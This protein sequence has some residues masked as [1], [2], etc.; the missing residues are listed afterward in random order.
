MSF[1][2]DLQ[3]NLVNGVLRLR[4][5]HYSVNVGQSFANE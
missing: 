2:L 4:F 1:S 3:R 5:P